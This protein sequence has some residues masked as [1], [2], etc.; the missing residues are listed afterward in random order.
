MKNTPRTARGSESR[1]NLPRSRRRRIAARGCAVQAVK[2]QCR[3]SYLGA[4]LRAIGPLEEG[5]ERLSPC[6]RPVKL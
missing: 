3:R 6:R 5:C 2:T 1:E 4:S